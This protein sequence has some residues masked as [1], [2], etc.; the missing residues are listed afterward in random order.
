M[1][2]LM[3]CG[4]VLKCPILSRLDF[5]ILI[6]GLWSDPVRFILNSGFLPLIMPR[7]IVFTD[8]DIYD[9]AVLQSIHLSFIK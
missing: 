7:F 3:V 8:N 4:H 5:K 1:T 2:W 6:E 9:A